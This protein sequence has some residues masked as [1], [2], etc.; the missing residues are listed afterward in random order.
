VEKIW[1]LRGG[2]DVR[3]IVH[4]MSFQSMDVSSGCTAILSKKLSV[5]GICYPDG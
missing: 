1:S 3:E 2:R 5:L 4:Q